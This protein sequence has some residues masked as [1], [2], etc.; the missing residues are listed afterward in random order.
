MKRNMLETMNRLE[1]DE[2][3]RDLIRQMWKHGYRTKYSCDGHGISKP[4]VIFSEGDGWLEEHALK[5]GFQKEENSSC[6]LDYDG[7]INNNFCGVCWAGINGNTVYRGKISGLKPSRTPTP[8]ELN[9]V[10]EAFY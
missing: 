6:C 5:Y 9:P 8:L 7:K 1:V 4:W 10:R 3:I 2:G